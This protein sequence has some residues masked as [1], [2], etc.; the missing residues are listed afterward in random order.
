MQPEQLSADQDEAVRSIMGGT[1]MFFM[2]GPAGS[3]KSYVI[4]HLKR[5]HQNTLVAA[6]TGAAANLIG[7]QTAHRV[8]G[9]RPRTGVMLSIEHD[10]RIRNCDLM[11]IDEISMASAQFLGQI[12]KRFESCGRSPKL[13]MVGDF[14]QLPPVEG[15]RIFCA[16]EW[17]D[18]IDINLTGQHRQTDDYFIAALNEVR[19]GCISNETYAYFEE[20]TVDELPEDATYLFSRRDAV[21]LTNTRHLNALSTP[22]HSYQREAKGVNPKVLNP[23]PELLKDCR[24]PETVHLKI[25]AQ[26]VMLTNDSQGRWFNGSN[27]VVT[28]CG[29]NTV[30]VMLYRN[31]SRV[32]VERA[33]VEV[34]DAD[35]NPVWAVSQMPMMLGWA[36]TIHKAQGMSLDRVGIDLANHFAPGQTYVALSRAKSFEGLF[37]RGR[38]GKVLVDPLV[39]EFELTGSVSRRIQVFFPNQNRGLFQ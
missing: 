39:Q 11:I 31:H 35:G 34:F 19:N 30:D 8:L 18:V 4:R 9:I 27:G 20:A 32:T 36:L 6:M 33:V 1:G 12:L 22:L 26:I 38:M 3:G 21:E 29:T 28:D 5:T 16:Q 10:A 2:T 25:G 37:L 23:D 15:D 24:L 13:L 7:G 14:H 17:E